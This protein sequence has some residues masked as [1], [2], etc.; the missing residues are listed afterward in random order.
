MPNRLRDQYDPAED[1][2]NETVAREMRRSAIAAY[3]AGEAA[4]AGQRVP[5]SGSVPSAA[6]SD[7]RAPLRVPSHRR[8]ARGQRGGVRAL[9]RRLTPAR[10]S[11]TAGQGAPGSAT[12]PRSAA[13]GRASPSEA[14][15]P[16]STAGSTPEPTPPPSGST[17]RRRRPSRGRRRQPACWRKRRS[18]NLTTPSAR[19]VGGDRT[20][21]GTNDD[22]GPTDASAGP[23][24]VGARST[25]RAADRLGRCYA[26]RPKRGWSRLTHPPHHACS[27]DELQVVEIH[28]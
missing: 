3:M 27:W 9:N 18:P 28:D 2:N 13:P 22:P 1:A 10:R 17:A 5:S 19:L 15:D 7:L 26:N 4:K 20:Y 21:L 25:L 12:R 16:R 14:S 24:P 6:T 11:P 8:T 23:A